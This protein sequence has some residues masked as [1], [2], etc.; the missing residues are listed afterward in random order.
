M[1]TRRVARG[2]CRCT[3]IVLI[4]RVNAIVAKSDPAVRLVVEP[5]AS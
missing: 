2:H 5:V 4:R 3:G 1:G